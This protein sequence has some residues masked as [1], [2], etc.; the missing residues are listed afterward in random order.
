MV[1]IIGLICDSG[2]D[3]PQEYIKQNGIFSVKL[4]VILDDV[5]YKDLEEIQEET[6]I[7]YM[8]TKFPKTSLPSHAEVKEGFTELIKKGCNEIIGIPISG[9]LSGTN[10]MFNL[11]AKE[12]MQENKDLCIEIIDTLSISIGTGLYVYKTAELIKK[13]RSFSEII[14][15]VK[16]SIPKKVKVFFTIPTLKYLKAGGRIG[17]VMGTLGDIINIKPVISVNE[18]GIYYTVSKDRGMKAAVESMYKHFE[19]FVE[20]QK[21]VVAVYKA[22]VQPI[23]NQFV[24]NILDNVQNMKNMTSKFTGTISSALLVHTGDG[25]VGIAALID[26]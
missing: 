24:Q 10:N 6:V 22:G 9:K 12:L 2:C 19:K 13:G 4:K 11:V 23:T 7:N 1:Y 20:N 25:L 5:M 26:E 18:E 17:K 3:L 8:K 21:F 15:N 14:K 16:E